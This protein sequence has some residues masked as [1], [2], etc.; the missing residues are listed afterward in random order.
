MDEVRRS[1]QATAAGP[2]GHGWLPARVRPRAGELA[3]DW[4][5]FGDR[6][7][8]E[9]FYDDA[10]AAVRHAGPL[11][12][13]ALADL[14]GWSDRP[15]SLEPTGLIFHMSRCG[16]TLA[17]QMLAASGANVVVSEAGPID[18]VVR[19]EAGDDERAELLRAMVAAL[20]QVRN[21]GEARYFLKLDSWHVCALPLFRAAFPRTPWAFLYRAP[22]AVM[23][24]HARRAGM[25]LVADLVP[26]AFYGLDPGGRA[27]G[28]DYRA[29]VLGAICDAAVRE[30]PAGGGVLVNYDEL[31]EAVWTRLLPHFDVMSSPEEVAAMTAAAGFDAKSPGV[32]FTPDAADKR[33]ATTV[34]IEQVVERR[35]AG[36]YQRLEALRRAAR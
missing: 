14:V 27:W 2:P 29:Q 8:T 4:A 31:P 17:S 15:A 23:V 34:A 11:V 22:T 12:S 36:V 33:R 13:T 3:I 30:Y 32:P 19:L 21:V 5:W 16:S 1:K 20:G 28:E 10:V 25:Q 24:S 18:A 6:R 7:L 35:L 26:P 9:P